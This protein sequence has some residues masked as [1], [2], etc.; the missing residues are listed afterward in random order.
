MRVKHETLRVV[1]RA[2]RPLGLDVTRRHFYSPIPPTSLPDS[3]WDG[4]RELRGI[5]FDLD[6]QMQW[7]ARR[8]EPYAEEFQP[9]VV[10][11]GY[12]F[13]YGNKS[14]GHG[15]ADV[16]YSVVRSRKPKRLVELGSGN[17]SV[18]I[19]LALER[20]RAEGYEC[21]YEVY[22]PYPND[23]LAGT[24]MA[25]DVVPLP[26]ERVPAAAFTQLD[27]GDVLFVDT[28]HTVRIGGDV[29]KIILDSLP[30]L[31]PGVLVH[32]HDIPMPYEYSRALIEEGF[33]WAEQYLLQAFLAYNGAFEVVAGL[34]ALSLERREAFARITP[35]I[36]DGAPISLWIERVR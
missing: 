30:L 28:T 32:F 33:Y 1:Q 31:K 3:T 14:F 25:M 2:L 21:L 8:V 24:A 9:P 26:A 17:S 15:D 22:D 11:S 10:I 6:E 12:R 19:R 7:V 16:L 36:I 27:D 18:V 23:L 35:S 4:Q 13:E 20:N 29:V 34:R 5:H